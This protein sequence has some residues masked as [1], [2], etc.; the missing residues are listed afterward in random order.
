MQYEALGVSAHRRS[1]ER[2]QFEQVL[3]FAGV[4]QL[5]EQHIRNFSRQS[6]DLHSMRGVLF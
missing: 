6:L 3:I 2:T 1:D 4:A 5:V